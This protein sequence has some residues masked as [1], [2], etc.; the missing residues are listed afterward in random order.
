M[1]H[2]VALRLHAPHQ[3]GYHCGTMLNLR[4]PP[5]LLAILVAAPAVLFGQLC[6]TGDYGRAG[7]VALLELVVIMVAG[8]I[9]AQRTLD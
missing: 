1:P 4:L 8:A 9:S 6:A 2:K 5:L 7:Q 3:S